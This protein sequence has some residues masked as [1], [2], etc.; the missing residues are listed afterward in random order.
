VREC[1]QCHSIISNFLRICPHCNYEFSENSNFDFNFNFEKPPSPEEIDLEFGEF[2]SFE[3]FELAKYARQQ[4]RTRFVQNWNPDGLWQTFHKKFPGEFLV[5][6]WL[7]GAIFGGRDTPENR[8]KFLKYLEEC[9]HSF[10]QVPSENWFKL[11]IEIEFGEPGKKYKVGSHDY[12]PNDFGETKFEHWHKTLGVAYNA[13][14]ET[15]KQAYVELAK[16]Y[17]PDTC[18]EVSRE[19]SNR[20]MQRIN[21]AYSEAKK[22]G[23][24]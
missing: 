17:H 11:H 12:K 14:S 10:K 16:R 6:Q 8:G 18:E 24:L 5:N 19:E 4:R 9:T 15:I 23:R 21:W 7:I 13:R 3:A 20:I 22:A 1:P 2:L